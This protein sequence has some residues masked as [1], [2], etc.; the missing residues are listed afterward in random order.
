MVL[1]LPQI[2][3][4][5]PPIVD[6]L[7]QRQVMF[8]LGLSL[9][10]S[11]VYG[12][13]VLRQGFAS[14]FIVQ[15]DARQ[16]V[17]WMQRFLDPALFPNDL[18]ADYFQSVAPA[19]YTGLYRLAAWIGIHPLLLSK[20]LPPILGVMSTLACFGIVLSM[21]P[22]PI[23]AFIS[24]LL[25]N[26]VLWMQDDLASAT[27]RAFIY[28]L[29]LGFCYFLLSRSLLPAVLMILLQGLFYPQS[30]FL[31]AG[32]LLLQVLDWQ[33]GRPRLT[34]SAQDY[35]FVGIGLAAAVAVML[36]YALH[37][38]EFAPVVTLTEAKQMPEFQQGGRSDFF[39][40]NP[41]EFWIGGLRS[42]LLPH[43]ERLPD[44]L[45]GAF[46]LPIALRFRNQFPLARQVQPAIALIPQI[47]VVSVAWFFVA[48]AVLFRLHLPSRYTQ[49]SFRILLCWA[50]GIGIVIGLDALKQW[51][52]RAKPDQIYFR[53]GLAIAATGAIATALIFYPSYTA[54]FPK[55]NYQVGTQPALY[56]FFAQQ[57]QDTVI[58]S[59]SR[60]A[61]NL[62]SFSQ[63]SVLVAQEYA[64]PYHM[65]YYR[66]FEQRTIDLIQAQYNP[67]LAKV[68]QF[69]QKYGIDFW[70]LDRQAFTTAYLDQSWFKQYPAPVKVAKRVLKRNQEPALTQIDQTCAV[71]QNQDFVVLKA[72][73][74]LNQPNQP[75]Q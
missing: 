40:D 14:E 61:N 53:N 55:T 38:S 7:P 22:I 11:L 30:V 8:W 73:C 34:Q 52:S 26:Q 48:H 12:V 29:F 45:I 21:F 18:I 70:L 37:L 10:F 68:K 43:I 46:L 36:P 54:N 47:F 5:N 56:R 63:R 60:E 39:T 6:R 58:A 31:S 49:H 15:D 50:A 16:H 4:P 19:G 74:L 23:A 27:P 32:L 35:W 67:K 33:E 57:P 62:P 59:L 1:K 28:P 24:S 2:S 9:A 17:F 72:A 69:I 75:G 65:G 20:L 13:L 51:A 25:L 71:F 44:L 64:I 3:F 66:P 42:G 41:W